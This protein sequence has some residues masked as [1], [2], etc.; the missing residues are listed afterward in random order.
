MAS[1]NVWSNGLA[2]TGIDLATLTGDYFSGSVYWVDTV[3]GLDANAGTERELPKQT[4]ASAHTA[5]SAG[6]IIVIE[7]SSAESLSAAQTFSKA[8]LTVIGLGS[9][10]TRPRYTCTGAV[11]MFDVTAAGVKFFNLYFPASTAAAT[12]RISTAAA[13]TW[14]SDCYFECGASDTNQAV[15]V[16]ASGHNATIQ[17]TTFAVTASRPAIGLAVTGA[18]TD[19]KV[20]SC[21]F[22]GGSYGWTDY[23]L[24]VSAAATRMHFKSLSFTGRSDLGV[25]ASATTYK[26]YGVTF[27]GS[28]RAVITA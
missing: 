22:D 27:T 26:M 10:S 21:T 1:P 23:A 13:E 14:V 3:N 8:D 12:A 9:G 16:A 28:G 25:T 4:L 5:A 15:R 6:D 19:T 2:G 24:K 18:V 7:A 20:L 11:A 17:N